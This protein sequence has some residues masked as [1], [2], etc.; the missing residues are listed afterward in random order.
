MSQP[1][2]PIYDSER[3]TGCGLCVSVCPQGVLSLVDSRAVFLSPEDCTYCGECELACPTQAVELYYEIVSGSQDGP[4][5]QHDSS[6]G[7]G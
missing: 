5:R 2:L 7:P 4:L 6:G 3:C 1:A